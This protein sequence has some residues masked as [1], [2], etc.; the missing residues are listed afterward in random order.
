MGYTTR[1]NGNITDFWPDDDE[2]T[3]YVSNDC[4]LSTIM[5]MV[6][7]KWPDAPVGSINLSSQ[8]IHTRCLY[9]DRYDGN[10]HTDFIVI[11]RE[12]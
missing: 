8:S 3:M 11:T 4:S 10:D 1:N 9:Y 2:N 5:G 12:K 6:K 7:D